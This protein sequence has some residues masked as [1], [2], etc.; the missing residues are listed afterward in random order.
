MSRVVFDS[1]E[2]GDIRVEGSSS[3]PD[4][5]A[6]I[7]ISNPLG[8]HSVVVTPTQIIEVKSKDY[9][10]APPER[11][12]AKNQYAKRQVATIISF[13][14]YAVIALLM[15]F[16]VLSTSGKIQARVVLT[17]SMS[18][19][20][21]SGD[22]VFLDPSKTN[23]PKEGD[24]VTYTGRRFDG[25][26]VGSFTHRIIGGDATSGFIL[27]GDANLNPDVQRV[28]PVDVV[29]KVVFVIPF[30]GQFLTPAKLFTLIPFIFILWLIVDRIKND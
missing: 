17:G 30:I 9:V 5:R 10:Q 26:A 4:S 11:I 12:V 23:L 7:T 29:G 21:N 8:Q 3:H 28:K 19:T 14:G 25:T 1:D 16:V 22:I 20:I 27:K 18:P 13:T 15:T 6:L 2:V 24:I